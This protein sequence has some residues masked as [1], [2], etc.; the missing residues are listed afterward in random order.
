MATNPNLKERGKI[1][2]SNIILPEDTPETDLPRTVPG[3]AAMRMAQGQDVKKELERLKGE[4]GVNL[5]RL[6]QLHEV[7]G[8]KRS[9]STDEYDSLRENLRNNPLITPI[10][11]SKRAD[12]DWDII[13]G[14]NRVDIYRELGRKEI[15]VYEVEVKEGEGDVKA[16]YANLL[17]P[18]LP[19]FE[20]Y[21]RFKNRMKE[22][23]MTPR[24]MAADS[25]IKESTINALM[26]FERL[27]EG[28]INILKNDPWCVGVNAVEDFAKITE[29]GRG[30]QVID[31]IALLSS[32][33]K[34]T[35]SNAIK[36]AASDSVPAKSAK[37]APIINTFKI[38]RLKF[39][40]VRGI[41]ND[42]RISCGN[43]EDR[44][45]LQ[46]KIEVLIESHIAGK[47]T[48]Q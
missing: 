21:M 44:A 40:Q 30:A 39:A 42:I 41:E 7:S 37:P 32:D 31:A 17:H 9:L 20:K 4:R 43:E 8:R 10:T 46:K 13:S 24:Q 5:V 1:D 16:F 18:S 27:P 12:G 35:Q 19:D 36:L 26:T 38:G 33:K 29:K 25:G 6:E 15:A 14:N 45:E 48:S 22:A 34:L 3:M 23:G 28:A 11:V 47:K 2:I